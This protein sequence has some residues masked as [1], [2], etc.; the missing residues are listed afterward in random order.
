MHQNFD[1]QNE[2]EGE[3]RRNKTL[4]TFLNKTY[5]QNFWLQNRKTMWATGL[6]LPDLKEKL[7]VKKN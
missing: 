1:K 7:N 2:V 4:C 6:Q 3:L 5:F